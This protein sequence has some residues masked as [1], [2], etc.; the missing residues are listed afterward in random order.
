MDLNVQKI[1]ICDGDKAALMETN[2]MVQV[3]AGSRPEV[4]SYEE[5]EKGKNP[6]GDYPAGYELREIWRCGDSKRN[7][8]KA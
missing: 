1:F 5:P 7:H 3:C 8:K 4:R 2:N 6:S